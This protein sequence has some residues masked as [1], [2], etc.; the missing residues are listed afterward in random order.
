MLILA[1]IELGAAI[2]AVTNKDEFRTQIQKLLNEGYAKDPKQFK[3][4]QDTFKCCGPTKGTPPSPVSPE[5][6]SK[7]QVDAVSLDRSRCYLASQRISI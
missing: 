2:F 7:E 3:P 1:V 5:L 4:I 6:C